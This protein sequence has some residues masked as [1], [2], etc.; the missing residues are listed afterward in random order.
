[1]RRTECRTC[2]HDDDEEDDDYLFCWFLLNDVVTDVVDWVESRD[3]VYV[4]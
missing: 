4:G 2:V 1:M 3:L